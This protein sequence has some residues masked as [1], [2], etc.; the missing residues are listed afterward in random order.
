M[1]PAEQGR[2]G[3]AIP[4]DPDV[5]PLVKW[6][7][8]EEELLKRV[9]TVAERITERVR[10]AIGDTA[11]DHPALPSDPTGEAPPAK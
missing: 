10:Q 5:A 3:E 2:S 8:V 9:K 1:N 7:E 4:A 6:Q 11:I